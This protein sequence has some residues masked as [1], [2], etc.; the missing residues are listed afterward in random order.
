MMAIWSIP[1]FGIKQLKTLNSNYQNAPT[2]KI[3][4]VIYNDNISNLIATEKLVYSSLIAETEFTQ[5]EIYSMDSRE[6][7][8]TIVENNT[9]AATIVLSRKMDTILPEV[10]GDLQGRDIYSYKRIGCNVNQLKNI[11]DKLSL[12]IC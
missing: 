10:I 11:I 5:G 9:F 3:Y 12:Q 2:N 7:H 8:S 6:F 4:Q 1:T